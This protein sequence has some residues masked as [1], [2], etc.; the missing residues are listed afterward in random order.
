[1]TA[2]RE[3]EVAEQLFKALFIAKAIFMLVSI[4]LFTGTAIK[5]LDSEFKE[6]LVYM[7]IMI[8]TFSVSKV[9]DNKQK[10]MY[11]LAIGGKYRRI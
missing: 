9:L 6:S 10:D 8:F 3:R 7:V 1:M 5:F 2:T 4:F 11:I